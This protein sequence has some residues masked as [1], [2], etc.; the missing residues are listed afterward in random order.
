MSIMT[1]LKDFEKGYRIYYAPSP[2][3][4]YSGLIGAGKTK[5]TA[6]VE[7]LAN[8]RNHGDGVYYVRRSLSTKARLVN[9]YEGT[10]Y[11]VEDG[12]VATNI[13]KLV[14]FDKIWRII[15]VGSILYKISEFLNSLGQL[16]IA[17]LTRSKRRQRA[18]LVL[19]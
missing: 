13:G 6:L 12:K 8:F 5:R 11:I 7:C 9:P 16:I 14:N 3:C 2:G 10:R 17:C 4:L 19:M 1:L 18:I 15:E